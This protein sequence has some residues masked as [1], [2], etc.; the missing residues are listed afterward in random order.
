MKRLEP[1]MKLVVASHNPGKVWE[2]RKLIAP[3]GL[4]AFSA[5]DLSLPEPDETEATFAGNARLKALAAATGA[6]LPAL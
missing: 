3:Y 1:G 5:A 6:N 4:E 2:I